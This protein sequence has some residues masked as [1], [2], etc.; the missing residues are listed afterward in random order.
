MKPGGAA[1]ASSRQANRSLRR[2][3]DR[4]VQHFRQNRY[5]KA[6]T[7][8]RKILDRDPGNDAANS[9]LARVALETEDYE[10]AK[11]LARAALE[12]NPGSAEAYRILG[13]ADAKTGFLGEAEQHYRQGL[14]LRND[15]AEGLKGLGD[16]LRATGRLAEAEQCFRNAL[17][18]R[19]DYPEA[20]CHLG[21]TLMDTG[22][23]GAAS[24]FLRNAA[25]LQPENGSY[26]TTWANCLARVAFA[27]TDELLF[28]DLL[29]LLDQPTVSPGPFVPSIISALRH[30]PEFSRIL[31]AVKSGELTHQ[32]GCLEAAETLA[33]FPLFLRVLTLGPISDLEIE[34]M[35]QRLR[36]GILGAV[37]AKSDSR[38]G[39]AF[40]A[41]L[42]RLCFNNEYLFGETPEETAELEALDGE[43]AQRLEND[44]DVPPVWLM[45]AA[46]YRPLHRFPWAGRL[47]DAEWPGEVAAVITQQVAEP[48][49]EKS[50][51]ARVPVLTSVKDTVSKAVLEQYEENPYPTWL[52]VDLCD[53]ARTVEEV[54]GDH[55]IRLRDADGGLFDNPDVLV[56][57]CGTGKQPLNAASKY[58]D[59]RIMAVDLSLTS[60]AYAM[61]KSREL[62][63]EDIDYAQGDILELA[64]LDRQFAVIECTGV[65][66]HLGDP[67]AGWRVLLEILHA[68]GVMRLGLYSEAGRGS[69]KK[70]HAYVAEKGFTASAGDIR[71]CRRDIIR[72]AATDPAMKDLVDTV[73]FYSLSGCR[74][75]IFHA[76]E[77]RFTLPEIEKALDG[78]G[79]TFLGFELPTTD[80]ARRFREKFPETQAMTSLECWHAFELE[81]PESFRGMY[82]FWV[83]KNQTGRTSP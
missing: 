24:V 39:L 73:D 70:A 16:V 37:A 48:V 62:G 6:K 20:H 7:L 51:R 80:M 18:V 23:Y 13:T 17:D 5:A 44:G 38:A 25:T 59:A 36:R 74:D 72:M 55:H 63:F 77:H 12:Y 79:L 57:G 31:E 45:A 78:L 61:R 4:A 26:W 3:Y 1:G 22:Q 9:L 68:G 50:L 43:I 21:L 8:I 33:A 83:Q 42:A 66:H 34:E 76:Q 27:A 58:L 71:R 67:L 46:A 10:T 29:S 2:D 60:L 81:N 30:D 69:M 82:M 32:T 64:G 19:L 56:A 40:A 28:G 52:K 54:L 49:E 41:A 47:L 35:L 14:A 15:D 75:M 11:G 65:L 53:R